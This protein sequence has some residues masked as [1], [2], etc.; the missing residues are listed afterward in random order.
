MSTH[1]PDLMTLAE[2]R[3]NLKK[4]LFL[5]SLAKCATCDGSGAIPY[6]PDPDGHWEAEQCQ[7]CH[8]RKELGVTPP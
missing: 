6:G 8:E 3:N 4:A 1:D 5:L 7:W 2:L